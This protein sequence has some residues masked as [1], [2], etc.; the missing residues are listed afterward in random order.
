MC[1]YSS[2]LPPCLRA[3][4]IAL[5]AD[6][7]VMGQHSQLGPTDPQFI[8][9][10]PEGTRTAPA[11]AILDQFELAKRQ[12]RQDPANVAAW[13]PIIR[14]YAPGLLTQCQRAQGQAV[15]M[16]AG[17]LE[18]FMLAGKP[19]AK[20]KANEIAKWFTTYENFGSHG[21]R[22]GRET[23]RGLGVEVQD[24]EKDGELQDALL[25]VH[26]ATMHTFSQ[27]SALTIIENHHGRAWIRSGPPGAGPSTPANRK[28]QPQKQAGQKN[29]RDRKSKQRRR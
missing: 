14:S 7:I 19:D 11:Q 15:T 21:E 3:T 27:T 17:W 25:S 29:R 16:V 2:P 8:I 22:V 26:H 23:A 18:R 20:S 4:M 5:S 6:A 9:S 10:M 13:M 28:R 12:C 1:V 24:L